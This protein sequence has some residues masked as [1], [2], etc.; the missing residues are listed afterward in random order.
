MRVRYGGSVCACTVKASVLYCC[1]VYAFFTVHGV[2]SVASTTMRQCVSA[3]VCVMRY[4]CV[5]A[6]AV[7]ASVLSFCA[8][9]L[10]TVHGVTTVLKTVH[11]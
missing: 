9:I 10:F 1:V 4:Q 5:H 3:R 2:R 6:C 11:M 8:Y 7:K